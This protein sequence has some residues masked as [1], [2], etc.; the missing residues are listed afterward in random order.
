MFDPSSTCIAGK[1]SVPFCSGQRRDNKNEPMPK[2]KATW[3]LYI[4]TDNWR[5]VSA[6]ATS[7]CPSCLWRDS[8]WWSHLH[9][10]Y[11]NWSTYPTY[12]CS[13]NF[14]M[15]QLCSEKSSTSNLKQFTWKL[16]SP[17][18]HLRYIELRSFTRGV[19]RWRAW[20]SLDQG[21]E[22]V[23]L[24]IQKQ[25]VKETYLEIFKVVGFQMFDCLNLHYYFV[26]IITG[27]GCWTTM[28]LHPTHPTLTSEAWWFGWL[29]CKGTATWNSTATKDPSAKCG[30]HGEWGLWWR[31]V[32][33]R[34]GSIQCLFK[35]TLIDLFEENSS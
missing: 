10:T 32:V 6:A 24:N 31:F 20:R 17:K 13:Q 30:R 1:F 33:A 5:V 8:E 16:T 4:T 27:C 18:A 34:R 21:F 14:L 3:E 25:A 2:P 28:T 19:L 7:F 11:T 15:G 9:H 35:F 23:G 29:S 26:V 22:R 12:P